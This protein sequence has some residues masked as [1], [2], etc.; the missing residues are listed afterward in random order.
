MPIARLPHSRCEQR[1]LYLIAA[2]ASF[3]TM[4]VEVLFARIVASYFG[5]GIAV[6]GSIITVL[7]VAMAAGYLFGG[8]LTAKPARGTTLLYGLV[9]TL[10]LAML[11]LFTIAQPMLEAIADQVPDPRYG[12]LLAAMTLLGSIGFLA[13]TI[14]PYATHLLVTTVAEAGLRVGQLSA[15][16][17]L[18]SAAGTI[19]PSYYLVLW[20]EIDTILMGLTAITAASAVAGA[21]A[22]TLRQR[23]AQQSAAPAASRP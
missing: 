22:F 15:A 10:A 16:T 8:R 18:G 12:S 19:V 9:F 23:G 5:T 7:L 2:W 6:W 17:T 3:A 21:V 4:A 13:G 20:L 14:T 1:Y 11:P